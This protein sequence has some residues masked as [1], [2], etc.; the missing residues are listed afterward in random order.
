[1]NYR[2]FSSD[3]ITPFS[4]IAPMKCGNK[5]LHFDNPLVM[6]ILN[7]TPDSFYDGGSYL[8]EDLWLRQT[9]KMISEGADIIDIGAMS[10]RPGA[11]I[12]SEEEEIKRLLPPLSK[13]VKTF[14]EMI[15]SVDTFRG[16]IV[17]LAAKEGAHL[18][19]DI[20]AGKMDPDLVPEVAASGLPYVL[21]HMQGTPATMQSSP[22]YTNITQNIKHYFEEQIVEKQNSGIKSILIDPGFGFGKTIEHNYTILRE[23]ETF[24]SLKCPILI[25]I[26][27]KSMIYNVLNDTPQNVLS[28]TSALNLFAIVKGASILRVHDVKEA[29]QIITLAKNLNLQN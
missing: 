8:S 9:E 4:L 19:N 1:M 18:I 21:M 15:F 10:S 22:V 26:S 29:K 13:L 16:K 28:A 7:L 17:K 24:T 25:G 11:E 3:K 5:V 6:G 2:M 27:R 20:S 12:I 23:L 14:P